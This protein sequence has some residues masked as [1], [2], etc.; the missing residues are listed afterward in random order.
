MPCRA[1]GA[2]FEVIDPGDGPGGGRHRRRSRRQTSFC[3]RRRG[4][5]ATARVPVR[6]GSD[7]LPFV[8]TDAGEGAK[9]AP[10]LSFRPDSCSSGKAAAS[11]RCEPLTTDVP[12]WRS[13]TRVWELHQPL[14]AQKPSQPS[15]SRRL[16]WTDVE[17]LDWF[18]GLAADNSK[19]Y[20]V[21]SRTGGRRR[22]PAARAARRGPRRRGQDVPAARDVRFS[23]TN[24]LQPRAPDCSPGTSSP[25]TFICSLYEATD[26]EVIE[27]YRAADHRR[28]GPRRR[29]SS[30]Q[31][32]VEP[33]RVLEDHSRTLSL[34]C[35][36]G[37]W[38]AATRID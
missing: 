38:C 37:W 10:F 35:V 17:A 7:P 26:D 27:V 30:A 3:G 33:D 32:E 1:T 25:L 15:P 14:S 23:K 8:R 22:R 28:A 16:S 12:L 31:A 19:S 2:S 20:L 36:A 24:C 11:G 21:G 13:A 18:R 9:L 4:P 6:R 34:A 29:D 5:G